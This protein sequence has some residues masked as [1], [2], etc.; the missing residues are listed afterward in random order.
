MGH[1]RL[2]ILPETHF[3][4][5]LVRDLPLQGTLKPDQVTHAIDHIVG[6][7]RWAP[8]E[9]PTTEFRRAAMALTEPSLA[10]ILKLIYRRQ[11]QTAGKTRFGDKTPDYVR[12]IPELHTLFPDAKF[13]H[14]I[15]DGHDVAISFAEVGWGHAYDGPQFSWS[16]AVR[17]SISYRQSPLAERILEVRYE[18]L[19][20]APEKTVRGICDFL[21]EDFEQGMLHWHDRLDQLFPGEEPSLHTKLYQPI[22]ANSV[23]SWRRKLSAIECFLI[24]ASLFRELLEAQYDLRFDGG[25]WRPAL[26]CAGAVMH[27]LA[28]LLNRV[29][30]ALYR[31][32]LLRKRLYI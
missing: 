28:P 1:S 14:L 16:R 29:L 18:D 13:I 4:T 22:Q 31:R 20:R 26:V 2:H 30:P 27:T 11:L 24:E 21:G 32:N 15:R 8:M 19:V 23:S 5:G 6:H 3:I 7:P 17:A 9:I 25:V 10:D 12:I